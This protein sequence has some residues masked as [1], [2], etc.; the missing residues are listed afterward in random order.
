VIG[1]LISHYRLIE[2][3]GGGGMGIVYKAEDTMLGRAVAL[4]FL[5]EAVAGDQ[6]TLERF[7]REARAASALNHPNICTIHEIASENERWFIVMEFLDGITLKY[8]IAGRALPTGD[9]LPLAIEIAD[10][11]DAAHAQN[12]IH[13]DVKPANIFVTRR[14]HAKV[15]DFG[16]AKMESSAPSALT[17]DVT[18]TVSVMGTVAYMSPEQ[19][20]GKLLDA[21]TDLFSFG[22][23][24]Y[25]MATGKQPFQRETTGS[26]FGAILHEAPLSPVRLNAQLP[27]QLEAII[28]K[29]LEKNRDLRYQSATEIRTDLQRLSHEFGLHTPDLLSS[30]RAR[31]RIA[32]SETQ[33]PDPTAEIAAPAALSSRPSWIYVIAAV[34]V[35]LMVVLARLYFPWHHAQALAEKDTVVVA[36][37]A[38]S[39]GD[40]VF[41]DTLKQTLSIALRQ[42]P[43]LNVISEAKVSSTLQM[44]TR[45]PEV[46]L[47]PDLAK[48]V[49][50]RSGSRAFIAGGIVPL[51]SQYVLT[52]SASDCQ[53]GEVLAQAQSAAPAKEKVL[54]ALGN[55]ASHLRRELGESLVT[56]QK[57]DVPL[58]QATTPSLEALKA[59]SLGVRA[60][61]QKSTRES[62]AYYK[63]AVELDPNFAAAYRGLASAYASLAETSRA[64]EYLGKAFELR[65]N[66]SEREKLAIAADYYRFVTGELD[67]AAQTYQEWIENY[68]RDDAGYNSL[69][70]TYASLGE[71][72][73][74]AEANR[75][76]LLLAPDVGGPYMNLGNCLLAQQ[77][78][79]EARQ[80]EDSALNRHLD[81]YVLRSALYAIAFLTRDSRA[82]SDQQAWFAGQPDS[83]HFGLALDSDTEAYAGR[84]RKARELT[85]RSVQ[86]AV[87]A[88]SRENAAVWQA[89][90][91]LREA[92]LG[93]LPQAQRLAAQALT[94]A[95]GSQGVNVEA[96]LAF[97]MA[98]E[99][100][101][102]ESM[103]R[104][105]DRRFPVD[106]QVQSLWLPAIHAQLDLNR[107]N[108]K[109]AIE[110]L[111][112]T[113]NMDFAQ[114]QFINNISCAY[115]AY[116]RGQAYLADHQGSAA[117]VEFRKI[118]DHSGS[119]WNCW[120][121]AL[122][123]LGSAR[124][125][126]LAGD[127]AKSRSAY[128]DLLALWKDADEDIPALKEARAEYAAVKGKSSEP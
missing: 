34:A 113:K 60:G 15:L 23:V 74:A 37:I 76:A 97:A 92:S 91:A 58:S 43:F 35:G 118:V 83:E 29:C 38:N 18:T 78:M 22:V 104:D 54:D 70:I 114:V 16:L 61:L 110:R 103:A 64:G 14:G 49:C 100:A 20:S 112:A 51:G 62:I 73:K 88:D 108:P 116:I 87:H 117:A 109:A 21:R 59:F 94:L 26:T 6:Q 120:T 96:A 75:R 46:P 82:L 56:V 31:V 121:G 122:A 84:L 25:E 111:R 86:S 45:P 27:Q 85:R 12:V 39:T 66:A 10:A 95:P 19:V 124:A 67:K 36:D 53:N 105:L 50:L 47:T 106:T 1:Q 28:N 52:L 40:P 102:A 68:P 57:F 93:N 55:A 69:A 63:K 128:E 3:L 4:K 5:P 17:E 119:V 42:S 81:D 89:N 99:S 107:K 126:R 33:G 101:R 79:V 77:K 123:R 11:L 44:M 115:P 7:R 13:R 48:E 80:I 41:D 72:E 8:R 98:G 24:L 125:Y 30:S 32:A 90:A 2:K 65:H 127:R 9:L 71:Y